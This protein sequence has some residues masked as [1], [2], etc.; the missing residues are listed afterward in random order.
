MTMPQRDDAL[1][2]HAHSVTLALT[3]LTE[4]TEWAIAPGVYG[5]DAFIS[6]EAGDLLRA[7]SGATGMVQWIAL[8]PEALWADAA[9]RRY[10]PDQPTV[11]IA[12][13]KPAARVAQELLRRLILPS[14]VRYADAAAAH[15]DWHASVQAAE[16]TARAV[17]AAGGSGGSV[18]QYSPYG[19][20]DDWQFATVIDG[21]TESFDG[22]SLRG[23]ASTHGRT[24]LEIGNLTSQEVIAITR[25]LRRSRRGRKQ[26][27]SNG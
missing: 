6:S 2:A 1:L 5:S 16:A 8:F 27:V 15:V 26:E 7:R 13:A 10:L 14:R 21:R 23:R 22:V 19:R 4:T 25:Y 18:M 20:S 3:A 12:M 24:A 9:Y 11:Q 17:I